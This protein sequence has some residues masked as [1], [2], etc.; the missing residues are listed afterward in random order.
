MRVL[1]VAMG[2]MGDTF[3]FLSLGKRMM[4]R[5]H[6]VT[7]VAS[8]Y[9]KQRIES[10]GMRFRESWSEEEYRTF[11]RNQATWSDREGLRAMADIVEN[12]TE[13][14]YAVLAQEYVR[15]ETVAAA[16]GYAFGARI[17]QEKLGL[18]LA[19]VHLQ[20]MWFRSI[21]DPPG[22][23]N[24]FPRFFPRMIDRLIDFAVDYRLA[25]PT[26]RYRTELGLAP[27]A[28]RVMKGWWNSPQLVMGFFPDWF[29]PPQ[30]DW[31]PNVV[32]P[33]FPIY[34]GSG[35][36]FDMTEVDA[37]LAAGDPPLVFSQSS[38]TT[39]TEYFAVSARA[40]VALGRRAVFLVAH[41]EQVPDCLPGEV[42]CYSFVPL[43]KLLPHA[44]AHIHH[45][46]IGT[47]GHTLEA[48][49]PQLT[50]PM[51]YDQPDNAQRLHRLGVSVMLKRK[52]YTVEAVAR[53]LA[54]LLGSR[55]VAERC[56]DFAARCRATDGLDN[57]AA[58]LEGL[59]ARTQSQPRGLAAR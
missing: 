56:R 41:P 18:P 25:R 4:E 6:E 31:P 17:A 36:S 46:G 34:K 45:G 20:P 43:E 50:V 37:F 47:I 49:I 55:A 57:A 14:V 51:V 53:G 33:G 30:P 1:L 16:Q 35:S 32:L 5:G 44:A 39:D 10:E 40:A 59:H 48:G 21:Y 9:F 52:A 11:V 22:L 2:S 42:R 38:I 15:G 54:E 24:W 13:R 8:G 12:M 28:K 7:L 26:N 29:N 58:A 19:T 23:P 27:K 3:P